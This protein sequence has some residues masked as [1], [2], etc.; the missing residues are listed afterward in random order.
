MSGKKVMKKIVALLTS[1]I[2]IMGSSIS[3]FAAGNVTYDGDA[4]KFVFAPGSEYSPTDLF[5]EFKDV[6]PGDSLTEKIT[7]SNKNTEGNTV[8]VYM[9]AL[10]AQEGTE[11]FLSQLSLAVKLSEDASSQNDSKLFEAGANETDGLTDWVLLGSFAP[12]AEANLEV[13]LNVPITLDNQYMEQIGYLDW[14]FKVEV[15]PDPTATASLSPSASVTVTPSSGKN[16]TITPAS[17]TGKT[18]TASGSSSKTSPK[19]GDATDFMFWYGILA[20][21]AGVILVSIR[22]KSRDK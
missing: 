5:D 14:E 8:K 6:M 4:K 11:D 21:S 17:S 13:T 2:L 10:G 16:T 3:A 15:I 12:G 22:L 20:L 1:G 7:I 9:R 18:T 19:T